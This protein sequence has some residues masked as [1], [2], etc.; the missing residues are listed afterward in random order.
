[1]RRKT[2]GDSLIKWPVSNTSETAATGTV[3]GPPATGGTACSK[4]EGTKV[5]ACNKLGLWCRGC[6][7]RICRTGPRP[8]FEVCC[9]ALVHWDKHFTAILQTAQTVDVPQRQMATLYIAPHPRHHSMQHAPNP[10]KQT[11]KHWK[12]YVVVS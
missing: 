7:T 11:N 12:S 8:A 5:D 1:M 9:D 3:A 2:T 6:G 4:T 10:A